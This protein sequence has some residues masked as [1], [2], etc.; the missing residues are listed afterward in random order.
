[1]RRVGISEELGKEKARELRAGLT[2][3]RGP[4]CCPH[5]SFKNWMKKGLGSSYPSEIPLSLLWAVEAV[6][7]K[8]LMCCPLLGYMTFALSCKAGD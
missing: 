1:M 4:H 3:D 2:K 5:L 6:V 8:L 7:C